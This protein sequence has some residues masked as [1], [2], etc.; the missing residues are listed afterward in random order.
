MKLR[1]L[2]LAGNSIAAFLVRNAIVIIELAPFALI[3]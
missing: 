2:R 1:G 3:A